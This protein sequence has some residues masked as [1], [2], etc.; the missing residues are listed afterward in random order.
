MA[1]NG[2]VGKKEIKEYFV[3]LDLVKT[4]IDFG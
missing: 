2:N 3:P 4:S 1:T